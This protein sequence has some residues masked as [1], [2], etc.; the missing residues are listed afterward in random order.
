M[1]IIDNFKT[2]KKLTDN[3]KVGWMIFDKKR[4]IKYL[5]QSYHYCLDELKINN[6]VVVVD[7]LHFKMIVR[8]LWRN[9]HY[10]PKSFIKLSDY[11]QYFQER[12]DYLFFQSPE[13]QLKRIHNIASIKKIITRNPYP[14]QYEANELITKTF[15]AIFLMYKKLYNLNIS[16][17]VNMWKCGFR[18]FFYRDFLKKMGIKLHIVDPLFDQDGLIPID[19]DSYYNTKSKNKLIKINNEIRQGNYKNVD[20]LYIFDHPEYAERKIVEALIK[21][22]RAKNRLVQII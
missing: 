6:D 10:I 19:R 16:E 8:A 3:K 11:E 22:N 12:V 13:Q 14:Y 17:S 9:E 7:L 1:Q 15:N 20:E 18:T 4:D 21:I 2:I 5:N